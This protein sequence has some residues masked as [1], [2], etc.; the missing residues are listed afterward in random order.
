MPLR[1]SAKARERMLD[2]A[3]LLAS[4]YHSLVTN[5][6]VYLELLTRYEQGERA[7]DLR[8]AALGAG[9]LL[10]TA[11][12]TFYAGQLLDQDFLKGMSEDLSPTR[13]VFAIA[14]LG[15]ALSA[16]ADD[17]CVAPMLLTREET[18]GLYTQYN[19]EPWLAKIESTYS[20]LIRAQLD[21]GS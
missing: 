14:R 12:R 21:A 7:A 6:G 1:R 2:Q 10:A 16:L 4:L 11:Q 18:E 19:L 8:E 13:A 15:Y 5:R 17:D 3:A 20:D 9:R